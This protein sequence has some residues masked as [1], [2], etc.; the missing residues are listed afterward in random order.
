LLGFAGRGFTTGA[1]VEGALGL[2]TPPVF[3][4]TPPVLGVV[5]ARAKVPDIRTIEIVV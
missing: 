4:V 2:A 5:W 3:G 1:L